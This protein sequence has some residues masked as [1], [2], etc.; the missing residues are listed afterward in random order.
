MYEHQD[1]QCTIITSIASIAAPR[2]I[3][4]ICV[5]IEFIYLAQNPVH[6]PDSLHLMV[7][8]LSDFHTFKDA[9]IDAE[10]RSFQGTVERLGMLMQFLA[11]MT[12]HLLITHCKHLFECMNWRSTDFMEQCVWILNRQE[13]MELFNLYALFYSHGASLVNAIHIEDEE[14]TTVNPVLSWVSHVL[15]DEA[16]SVH[17][18]CQPVQNH[19]LKGIFSEDALTTEDEE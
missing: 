14:V 19:F 18:P 5:L 13:S 2:F 10:A 15:P 17:G 8:A 16:H 3:H 4:S 12:E 1:I 7:Q 11:D 9:I 6:S